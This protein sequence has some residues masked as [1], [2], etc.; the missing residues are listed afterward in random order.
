M[1]PAKKRKSQLFAS[2]APGLEP[3]LFDE[4][5][6]LHVGN[7][8]LESGGVSF[9]GTH[10]T[11]A[12]VNLQS[13]I[14]DRILLRL[15]SFQAAHLNELE[16][17]AAALPLSG[18]ISSDTTVFVNAICKKSKIYHS[19]AAAE[20]IARAIAGIV[21]SK[22]P[23]HCQSA[24]KAEV[25]NAAAIQVR[26]MRDHATVSLDSSGI[27]LHKR[28]YR[29]HVS[30]APL[31][32]NVAAAALRFCQYTGE[33]PL[34]NPMC[35]SGTIA[36][37]AALMASRTAPGIYRQ[38]AFETWPSFDNDTLAQEKKRARNY[39]RKMNAS[40]EASD[41]SAKAIT[42]TEHNVQTAR[43]ADRIHV[44][45]RELSHIAL[46]DS[47]GLLIVNPPWG[48]RMEPQ[49]VSRLYALIGQLK[50]QHPDWQLCLITSNEKFAKATN[51]AFEKIS[52]PIPMGGV[53]IK[54]YL[55]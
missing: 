22:H 11:I 29:T 43:V 27:H 8:K 45:E 41:V 1:P 14:A 52:A 23:P 30:E 32:E 2:C 34:I 53:R 40:I 49:K 51:V 19:G 37:E 18:F 31:R 50:K 55:G 33:I 26:I 10:E 5:T 9:T 44:I 12:R 35:G 38:F 16:K 20:R 54:F 7:I 15:G 42:A 46:T 47:P 17:K 24:Q 28:G 48:I 39:E 36:I 6:Q 3:F 13:R 25:N 4:L 21:K